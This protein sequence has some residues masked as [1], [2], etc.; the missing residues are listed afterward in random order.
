MMWA[1]ECG[2]ADKALSDL[3]EPN[4]NELH[5][6]KLSKTYLQSLLAR[7]AQ[8]DKPNMVMINRLGKNEGGTPAA[9]YAANVIDTVKVAIGKF[10]NLHNFGTHGVGN[11]E[12]VLDLN[13][14]NTDPEFMKLLQTARQQDGRFRAVNH[15][16]QLDSAASRSLQLADMIAYSRMWIH[17]GEENAQG[18]SDNYGIHVL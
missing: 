12:L 14:H 17:N 7:F 15:I 3:L 11:V 8:T 5:A 13:Q 16:A 2:R 18:L 4:V 1:R 9:I 10:R 6:V